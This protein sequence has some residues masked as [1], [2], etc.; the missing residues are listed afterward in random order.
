MGCVTC[1]VIGYET[2]GLCL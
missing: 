1:S 2:I